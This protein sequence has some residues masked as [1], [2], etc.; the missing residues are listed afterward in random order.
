MEPQRHHPPLTDKL[1]GDTPQQWLSKHLPHRVRVMLA[2]T[3]RLNEILPPSANVQ[4]VQQPC[5]DGPWEPRQCQM[6]TERTRQQCEKNAIWEGRLSTLRWFIE[7]IGARDEANNSKSKYED[8]RLSRLCEMLHLDPHKLKLSEPEKEYLERFWQACSR[9]CVHAA[10]PVRA[11]EEAMQ[12][13]DEQQSCATGIILRQLKVNLY[14]Q[15][16][17]DE[18]DAWLRQ[19]LQGEI[20][21]PASRS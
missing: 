9:R 2:G 13:N 7:F 10:D 11:G 15:C 20:P 5:Q 18:S 21:A 19:V 1:A 12:L 4:E 8:A 16:E 6:T 14:Q 17:D 3:K